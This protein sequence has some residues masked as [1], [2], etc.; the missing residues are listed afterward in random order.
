MAL[1]SYQLPEPASL[2][3]V[4]LPAFDFPLALLYVTLG[5]G[6]L[7]AGMIKT[8]MA[9]DGVQTLHQAVHGSLDSTPL[10]L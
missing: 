5:A 4:F 1:L 10:T 2:H 3:T 7:M 9:S 6:I 8:S